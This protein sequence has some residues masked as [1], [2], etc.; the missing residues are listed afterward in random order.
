MAASV[1]ASKA[2][3]ETIERARKQKRWKAQEEAWY[4]LANTT[5]ATLK[6]FRSGEPILAKTFKDLCKVV[7]IDDWESLVETDNSPPATPYHPGAAFDGRIWVDRP[8]ETDILLDA[9]R[10][11]RR[12]VAISGISGIGKTA[13]AERAI[14]TLADHRQFCRLN[15]DRGD[16]KAQFSNSGAELLRSL[17]EEVTIEDQK[18]DDN[19]RRHLLETLRDRPLR[20]Q[21]DSLERL[22]TEEREEEWSEFA[23]PQW[24]RLFDDILAGGSEAVAEPHRLQS[25]IVLTGQEIP[26]GLET[27]ASRYPARWHAQ[28]LRGLD[29]AQQLALFAKVG[30][31][32]PDQLKVPLFKGDLG[33]S[34]Q[35]P[36]ENPKV[37]LFKG[38]LGGSPSSENSGGSA[39]DFLKR[40]GKIYRGHP[41]VLRVIAEDIKSIC[42]QPC[43][44]EA[45]EVAIAR[46][47][48]VEKFET[49]EAG[50]PAKLTRRKLQTDVRERIK[51]SLLRL[52]KDSLELL[53]RVS[54]FRRSVPERFWLALL[55]DCAESALNVLKARSLAEEV[56]EVGEW[57]GADGEIPLRQ[58]N[59][60]RNVANE[61]LRQDR[62]TWRAA[63]R[64]AAALWLEDYEPVADAPNLE[65]VRGY[66]EAFY[67][68]CD[69]EDWDE[70]SE[71]FN[72]PIG[73]SGHILSW[74]LDIWGHYPQEIDLCQRIL[75]KAGKKI[76]IICW[77]GIGNAYL[78]L[79]N[80]SKCIDAHENS[81]KLAREISERR[82]EGSALGNLGVAYANLGQ[83][84]RAIDF[85]S[86]QLVID[87]K[88][89][90]RRGEGRALGNLGIAYKKLGLI[91]W[92][93]D[94][95]R[96]SLAIARE[97]GDRRG[98]GDALGN[99]GNAYA[100]L[101]QIETAIDFYRQNLVIT[102][103]IG[104]RRGEALV[105]CNQAGEEI[106]LKKH[107]EALAHL[108]ASLAI[109][110]NIKFPAGEA[111]ALK[112]LATLY[113]QTHQPDRARDYC[114]QAL[115]LA[116]D[117]GIPLAA[118]CRAL[119]SEI[120]GGNGDAQEN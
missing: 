117:L 2:G 90:H 16:I 82:G 30:I 46:Y 14:A 91:E 87:K 101:G 111:L 107:D 86:Q 78:C 7:G 63:E 53:R 27:V 24:L 99:L 19:L 105:L 54:V 69:A 84:E 4:Q 18:S 55:P 50:H 97:I 70:A 6:R 68:Y 25:Q 48:Q 64:Q 38:D 3:L 13:L 15:L 61:M 67:H 85:Y 59:L 113:H 33:G 28:E 95:Y 106:K 74:Q 72:Q 65:T 80:Y 41:L 37:T 43:D 93:I 32:P 23:D 20:V 42:A 1:K 98:E 36:T 56:W 9:L 104:D 81:L 103:E 112:N 5:L 116:T 110:Q 58:H 11:D 79:G 88:I 12:I 57:Y 31:I 92:A 26:A 118:D 45:L 40:V 73:E 47:W 39:L 102:R 52:P 83:S 71:L 22:L 17:G 109:F 75:G 29:E 66:L 49:L 35:T 10:G 108:E 8:I 62:A 96:K 89:G 94:F 44:F 34:P 60:I 100:D 51:A 76:D 21:I 119:L 120:E 77:T 114:R 115:Q